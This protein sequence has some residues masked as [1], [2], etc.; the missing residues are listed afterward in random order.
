MEIRERFRAGCVMTRGVSDDP[1]LLIFV[2]WFRPRE[3]R[4]MWPGR[5]T[6]PLTCLP[7]ERNCDGTIGR[8]AY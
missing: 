1:G 2:R 5:G 7:T 3:L 6:G 8:G 4:I